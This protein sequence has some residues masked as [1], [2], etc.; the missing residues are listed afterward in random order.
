MYTE[1]L[2][3]FGRE[4]FEICARTDTRTERHARLSQ[5]KHNHWSRL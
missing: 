2:L 5:S 1:H 4:V 3:K